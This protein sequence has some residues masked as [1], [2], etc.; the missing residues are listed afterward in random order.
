MVSE[1]LAARRIADERVLAAMGDVPR[2]RFVAEP[3]RDRAYEDRAL[4]IAHGQTISQPWIVAA[5]CEALTLAPGDRVLEIGTGTGYSAAVLSRLGAEVV[6]V[7][8]LPE[9][10]AAAERLL[11]ELGYRSI[12]VRVGDGSLGAPD[13]APFDA[14]AVHAALPAAPE[15]LLSQ[16]G[17]G[18]R[19]LAPVVAGVQEA[20]VR[21]ERRGPGTGESAF[22]RTRLA[23]CRFVPLI[24]EQGFRDPDAG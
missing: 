12:E 5:I 17:P 3:D 6:T 19:L 10:A 11:G 4:G 1:Q 18:G 9:L 20:L 13:A 14:I 22:R 16:L 24:G 7:E 21:F 23:A 2:E 8:R 15:A